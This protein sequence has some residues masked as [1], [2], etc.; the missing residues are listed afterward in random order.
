MLHILPEAR[1][2]FVHHL[3]PQ[4]GHLI[5]HQ[6]QRG[7]CHG[8]AVVALRVEGRGPQVGHPAL[9]FEGATIVFRGT[10]QCS[11]SFGDSFQAIGLFEREVVKAGEFRRYSRRPMRMPAVGETGV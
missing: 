4:D 10:A 11:Q 2:G 5:A 9:Q 7:Q 3:R 8:H 1:I 6:C